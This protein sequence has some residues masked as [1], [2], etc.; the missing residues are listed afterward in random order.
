MAFDHKQEAQDMVKDYLQPYRARIF[1]HLSIAGGVLLLPLGLLNL[2]Q[3]NLPA[4][5]CIFLILAIVSIDAWQMGKGK[6]PPIPPW[7][8]TLPLLLGISFGIQRH[9]IIASLWIYPVMLLFFFI[10]PRISANCINLAMALTV[11]ALAWRSDLS[12]NIIIRILSSSLLTIVFVNLI[13]NVMDSLYDKLHTAALADYLTG[14]YNR[15]HMHTSLLA[16]QA[17]AKRYDSNASVLL[18]DVDHFKAI[19]DKFGHSAGDEVLRKIVEIFR[20]SLR[21]VDTIFRIGGEEFL[22]LLPETG[23]DQAIQVA[24]KLRGIIAGKPLVDD[25]T[26]TISIGVG[27]MLRDE[28]I[29]ALLN[30]CDI[31]LYQAKNEGRNHV[32]LAA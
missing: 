22:I 32:C 2:Y 20:K 24:E 1:Y 8:I 7:I 18:L 23:Q 29:D 11:T 9:G 16:A 12:F 19:N 25:L 30:R 31:A 4:G 26:V 3:H 6:H 14:A 27:E 17:H 28:N 10:L 5:V 15:R 13:L 21:T